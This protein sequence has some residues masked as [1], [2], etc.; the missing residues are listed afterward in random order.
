MVVYLWRLLSV[1]LL[2]VLL[3][4]EGLLD[5]VSKLISLDDHFLSLLKSKLISLDDHFLSLLKSKVTSLEDH[6]F[7]TAEEQGDLFGRPLW[8]P[9]IEDDDHLDQ[10]FLWMIPC[11][12]N[13]FLYKGFYPYCFGQF[14]SCTENLPLN[15][16]TLAWRIYRWMILLLHE[17]FIVK[18]FDSYMKNFIILDDLILA[19]RIYHWMI[20]LSLG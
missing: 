19:Q 6:F 11:H 4:F 14:N 8:M 18:R 13:L 12:Q 1:C 20:L 2:K 9:S 17:E 15:T 10:L 5:L 7:I 16:F 3:M